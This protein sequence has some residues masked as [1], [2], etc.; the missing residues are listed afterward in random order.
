[1]REPR[2]R[3][4]FLLCLEQ[5]YVPD[6]IVLGLMSFVKFEC[7][8]RKRYD[9]Y[10]ARLV[11]EII[12]MKIPLNPK[13]ERLMKEIDIDMELIGTDDERD[14][15]TGDVGDFRTEDKFDFGTD[16]ELNIFRDDELDIGRDAEVDIDRDDERD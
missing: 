11:R 1:M 3:E 16:D 14:I 8:D 13:I 7:I 12:S 9:S 6:E 4:V 10:F 5:S 2:Y 15:A